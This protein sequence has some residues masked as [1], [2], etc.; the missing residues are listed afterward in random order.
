MNEESLPL[1]RK[2][3][4]FFYTADY[5]ENIPTASEDEEKSMSPLQVA[6]RMFALG[7]QYDIPRLRELSAVK[8]SN[9]L[10][11]S[12][13]L[14]EFLKSIPDVYGLTPGS[15]RELR[16]RAVRFGR[17][18]L[19]KVVHYESLKEVWNEVAVEC[20]EFTKEVLEMYMRNPLIGNCAYQCGS[21]K[22]MEATQVRCSQCGRGMNY[23]P[24]H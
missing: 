10:G 19:S 1:V 23:R 15:V 16:D 5:D 9:R 22:E 14:T 4:D 24:T 11:Q 13:H 8:Y 21:H 6:S 20:P 12:I 3:V 17:L 2:M 7:D 18:Y